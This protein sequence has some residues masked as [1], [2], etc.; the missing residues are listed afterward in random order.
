MIRAVDCTAEDCGFEPSSEW[1]PLVGKLKAAKKRV[2]L[3]L[4][5]ADNADMVGTNSH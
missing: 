1:V 2:E 5:Y 4:S 3:C